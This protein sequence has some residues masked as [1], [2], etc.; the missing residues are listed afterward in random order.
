ME[1]E[2][3]EY[4]KQD[5]KALAEIIRETWHYD[6][7]SSPET[8]VKLAE[9]FLSSCLVKGTYARIAVADGEIAGII[10][11]NHV[12]AH[13]ESLSDRVR[14]IR[15]ALSLLLSKEGR[16]VARMFGRISGIDKEL[17]R[18]MNK[19]Y[20]AEI[21]LFAVR[22]ACRG[23]GVGKR[24]FESALEYI[25]EQKLNEFYL[26]TDTSCNYGFYEHQGMSRKNEKAHTFLIN[27]REVDMRFFIYDMDFSLLSF[28]KIASK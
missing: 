1:I 20:P 27:G 17:L 11:V 14:Q 5:F 21:V 15:S 22:S 10:L 28:P 7:F 12:A 19:D 8:A 25:K 2:L 23:N 24:L 18:E 26:F 4:Q 13:R 9:V 6:S 3:R 16:Q